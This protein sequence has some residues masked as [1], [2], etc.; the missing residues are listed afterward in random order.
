MRALRTG[1][2][3]LLLPG[4]QGGALSKHPRPD[5]T[6]I[7]FGLTNSSDYS[8]LDHL[9]SLFDTGVL[10]AHVAAAYQLDQAA[11]AFRASKA[12]HIIGKVAVV[13]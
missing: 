9:A 2:V 10:H 5:V 4:G 6:Q 1:G 3:Y 8:L 12:G 7:N 11:K 13:T